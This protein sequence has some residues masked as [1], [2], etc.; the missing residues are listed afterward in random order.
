MLILII[1]I[2]TGTIGYMM[3]ED[4]SFIDSFYMTIITMSTVG[5]AEVNELSVYGK[6]FTSLLI[7]ISFGTFAYAI[8]S[9]TTYLVGGEY[10]KYFKEYKT[11]KSVNKMNN[12]VIICGF[13]RVGRQVADDLHARGDQFVIIE[14]DDQVVQH[15]DYPDSYL[16]LKGDATHDEILKRANIDTARGIIM[17]LPKDADNIYIVLAAREFSKTI[18][19]ISRASYTSA[20]SKLK[21]AGANN[22]IMPDSIGGSHM[23]SL[24]SNPD[25]MEFLDIIRVQGYQGANIESIAFNELPKEMRNMTIGQLNEQKISGV[26]IIGFKG[27]D[28]KYIINPNVN[29]EVGPNSKLFVLGSTEQIKKLNSH[30]GLEH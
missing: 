21:L 12:H 8:S 13:G 30:F 25:V 22:I 14:N 4:W 20:V 29:L 24:V 27:V 11:I 28:G 15:T 1:V 26:T 6:L 17:C 7:V 2:S 9:I 23:A 18:L 3:I 10:K 19:I 5:F 16:F